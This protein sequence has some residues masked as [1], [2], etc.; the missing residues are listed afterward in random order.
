MEAF[1][2]MLVRPFTL[3]SSQED[4]VLVGTVSLPPSIWW[5]LSTVA[6]VSLEIDEF[7]SVPKKEAS[8]H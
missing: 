8:P 1:Q 2:H 6:S 4:D 7:I 3:Q 5:R